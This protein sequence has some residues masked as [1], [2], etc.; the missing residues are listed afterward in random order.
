MNF[1]PN[2][3]PKQPDLCPFFFIAQLVKRFWNSFPCFIKKFDAFFGHTGPCSGITTSHED[4][5]KKKNPLR[6]FRSHPTK[7]T[8]GK[9]PILDTSTNQTNLKC[10]GRSDST[11]KGPSSQGKNTQKTQRYLAYLST[12]VFPKIEV[13]KNGWFIMEN[14][15]K[16]DDLGVPL[17]SETP[18]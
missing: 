10:F 2:K 14:P 9:I 1:I 18:T 4:Q 16:M 13:P 7:N 6:G 3:S 5:M 8:P 15:I 17:F 12:W 11:C